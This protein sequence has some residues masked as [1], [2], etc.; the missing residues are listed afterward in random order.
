V[1]F[2]VTLS[3]VAVFFD[4]V[5]FHR[6]ERWRDVGALI[7]AALVES[8]FLR[9][10]HS[11]WRMRGL[12]DAVNPHLQEWGKMSRVGFRPAVGTPTP[13]DGTC[14]VRRLS[15]P[16]TTEPSGADNRC[17][18]PGRRSARTARRSGPAAGDVGP[19]AF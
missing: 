15:P 11:F 7:M 3:L 9:W 8:T 6:Y 5:T 19:W 13:A 16:P 10:I 2:G 12:L 1:G 14:P 4:E 18:P 17:A